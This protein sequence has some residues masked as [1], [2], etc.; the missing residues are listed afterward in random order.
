MR[1][2]RRDYDFGSILLGSRGE[3]ELVRRIRLQILISLGVLIPNAIGAGLAMLIVT[4]AIRRPS[5]FQEHLWW[6]NFLVLPIYVGAA[7]VIGLVYGTAKIMRQLRWVRHQQVPTAADGRYVMR[8]PMVLARVQ[9]F[10]WVIAVVLFT[11][12][13]GLQDWNM[14]AKVGF[15]TGISA[16]VV[17]VF[18]YLLVEFALRP[19][20]AQVLEVN[21]P[22]VS[23]RSGLQVRTFVTWA[24]GT[25]LPLIGVIL[26]AALSYTGERMSRSDLAVAV[27]ALA[28]IAL[29]TSITL[30]MLSSGSIVDPIRSVKAGM[31]RVSQGDNDVHV[32][33]YDGS[34]LGELQQG[35]N[36]MVEGL[37]ERERMR[38]IFGRHV[39]REVAE[40]A[41]EQ[42]MELGGSER[43]VAVIFVD[44]IGSTALAQQR[45]PVEVVGILN[46][47]FAVVVNAI[48]RH[49]GL[50]NKFEGDA[51][52][53]IFGAPIT[54]PDAA[55]SALAAAREIA[56]EL[57]VK[58]PELQAGV[59]V[60]Y[61]PA[62]AGNIGAIE[63]FEYTVIGDPV[64]EG[65]R[66]SEAAKVDPTRPM[67]S[68]RA[69]A[70]AA[71]EE[72]RYWEHLDTITL[73]GRTDAT[74]V[75]GP[76]RA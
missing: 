37:A 31:K 67:A 51:V 54:V 58:V 21:G 28:G 12:L 52:L 9:L 27:L 34:E 1:I 22:S 45:S 75:Y 69:I 42:K 44:V 65:A 25:G 55:G 41:L 49:G 20:A 47:F 76:R 15:A 33:V 43:L 32:V 10:F 53:A 19:L 13:Y 18:S 8:I 62:V 59:G 48:G 70:A 60:A 56:D 17:S 2:L 24:V 6:I 40:A 39:G 3:S 4:V 71:P 63:R 57:R 11:T 30:T 64:N 73:R 38:D 66:L 36:S 61:G 35:F 26:T 14:T 72:A 74:E 29:G 46:R 16:I 50:V 23:R 5:V 68:G 7:F